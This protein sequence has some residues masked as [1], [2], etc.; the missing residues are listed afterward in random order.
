[1]KKSLIALGVAAAMGLTGVAQADTT[2]YGSVRLSVER[3]D[4]GNDASWDVVNNASRLGVRGSED[5]GGG[6][7]AIYQ[8]E[9]GVKADDLATL[10]SGGR[11]AMV[12]LR[13]GFGTFSIG[14][15]WTPFYNA[16]AIT[17]VFNGS[18]SAP[19]YYDLGGMTRPS[20]SIAYNSPNF[21]GLSFGALASMDGPAGKSGV[22]SYQ[23]GLMYNNA[24]LHVG[25]GY[26]SNEVS[27]GDLWGV[28]VGYEFSGINLMAAYRDASDF[29]TVPDADS[30][31]VVG[32]YTFGSNIASLSYTR[33]DPDVGSTEDVWIVGLTHRMSSRTRVWVEYGRYDDADLDNLSIGIRHDF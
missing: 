27:D 11:I 21:G 20:N 25:A 5:L 24:G 32:Q 18:F 12:G 29:G 17:D 3:F 30:I 13:G 14:R 2:L 16:I 26:A 6:L 8:Y 1:M 31:E 28:S 33:I 10:T 7:S 9:F 22:D 23:V 15:Q 19:G 4:D